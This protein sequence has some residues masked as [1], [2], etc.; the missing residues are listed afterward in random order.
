MI[1]LPCLFVPDSQTA[2]FDL[3]LDYNAET[4]T[5][6]F[7]II[8]AFSAYIDYAGNNYTEIVTGGVEYICTYDYEKVKQMLLCSQI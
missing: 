3:G 8:N 6:T 2:L 1:E 5:V 7:V 4:R